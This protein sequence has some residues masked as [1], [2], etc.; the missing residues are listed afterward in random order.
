MR[1]FTL[2]LPSQPSQ[3]LQ[4]MIDRA[5]NGEDFNIVSSEESLPDL[6]GHNILFA[7]ELNSIGIN[8][9]LNSILEELVSRGKNSLK[10]SRAS[11]LIHSG[12]DNFTKTAA[13]D[14]V[15]IA[16]QLGCTFPGRP[17]I[18]ANQNLDNYIPLRKIYHL[19][20][21]DICLQKSEE[22]G[23]RLLS[24]QL[25]FRNRTIAVLH[26]SNKGT[27]NT[28]S[29]WE[30]IKEHLQDKVHI[31]E[32][33]LGNGTITDCRGCSY[34]TCKYFGKQAKCFYGGVVVEEVYP[35]IQDASTI[36]LLCPNYNDMITANIVAT[37]N[38]LTALFRKTKFY[39]KKIFAV[40]VSGYSGGDALAKQLISSLNMN[41]TFELPPEFSIMATANDPG[42]IN[43]VPEIREKAQAFANHI[44]EN[45]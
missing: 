11:I 6:K 10:N 12:F 17:V 4:K 24:T 9:K 20:L 7:V 42:S 39:D 44:L 21:E 1:P 2:I 36:I 16:N 34:R 38:R 26:S 8:P 3:L 37:I 35:A 13:Q 41:K 25:Y 19:P 28:Y 45:I 22:L 14:I 23:R 15:F 27:S 5:V 18:E 33:Y 29:L 43:N 31:N 30:M 40:I 32:V